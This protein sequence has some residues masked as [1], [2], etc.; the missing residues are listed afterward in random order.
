MTG[1]LKLTIPSGLPG[2]ESLKEYLLQEVPENPLFKI[3]QSTEEKD[4]AFILVKPMHYFPDYRVKINSDILEEL[5]GKSLEDLELY[6]IVTLAEKWED[7]TANLLAPLLV[8]RGKG[9]ARQVILED[10]EYKTKHFIF[11]PQQK[12]EYG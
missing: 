4:L 12:V 5:E 8:N 6:C 11:S 9:L 10:T 2:L 1:E 3:L 7:I